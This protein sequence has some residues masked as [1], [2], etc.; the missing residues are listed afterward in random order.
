MQLEIAL[1]PLLLLLDVRVHPPLRLL[2]QQR[3]LPQPA[4]ALPR[5]PRLPA[6]IAE[7]M[8]ARTRHVVAPV[9][10]RHVRLA[11]AAPHPPLLLGAQH[12]ARLRLRAPL[13]APHARMPHGFPLHTHALP[14]ARTR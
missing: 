11:S 5:P 1:E 7:L 4:R 6:R 3:L 2:Q 10:E 13:L 9:R 14:A 8:A 12:Q